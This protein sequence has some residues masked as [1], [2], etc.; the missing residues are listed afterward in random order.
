[1]ASSGLSESDVQLVMSAIDKVTYDNM[2][3]VMKR[4]F[5]SG[6]TTSLYSNSNALITE[7]KVEPR[8]ATKY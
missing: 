1:M 6:I 4:V 3:N 8:S 7:V 2:K 5:T